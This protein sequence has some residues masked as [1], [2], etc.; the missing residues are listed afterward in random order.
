MALILG[1]VRELPRQES[2]GENGIKHALRNEEEIKPV[3]FG[4]DFGDGWVD[5]SD[6]YG[7]VLSQMRSGS[8]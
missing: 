8:A 7:K 3:F 5:Q 4:L 2:A 6:G 1:R